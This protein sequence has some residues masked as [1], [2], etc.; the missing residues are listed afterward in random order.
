[1]DELAKSAIV[2]YLLQPQDRGALDAG[3]AFQDLTSLISL[4]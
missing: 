3:K 1:M 2:P 4:G